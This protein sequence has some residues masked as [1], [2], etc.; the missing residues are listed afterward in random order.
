[1]VIKGW[2]PASRFSG[3]A[4]RS[5]RKAVLEDHTLP[6]QKGPDGIWVFVDADLL[7]F[8]AAIGKPSAARSSALPAT[9]VA[10]PSAPAALGSLP[11]FMARAVEQ[12]ARMQPGDA[13]LGDENE[14]DDGEAEKRQPYMGIPLGATRSS[15]PTSAWPY[16]AMGLATSSNSPRNAEMEQQLVWANAERERLES[17]Y[18]ATRIKAIA[19]SIA[20]EVMRASRGDIHAAQAAASAAAHALTTLPIGQLVQ[21]PI[22]IPYAQHVGHETGASWAQAVYQHRSA[23]DIERARARRSRARSPRW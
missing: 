21:D 19:D 6:A 7:T 2:K 10:S 12:R 18:R 13:Q 11:D 9:A 4:V 1:M 8:A 23:N 15:T 5:L 17:T 14:D 3:I 22:A 16:S 20:V